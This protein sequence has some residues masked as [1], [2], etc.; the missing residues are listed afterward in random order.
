MLIEVKEN[1]TDCIYINILLPK[2]TRSKPLRL[3]NRALVLKQLE[4]AR[5]AR[6]V[7]SKAEF[8]RLWKNLTPRSVKF[9]TSILYATNHM[10]HSRERQRY[11]V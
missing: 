10:P 2:S 8:R 1:N 7:N 4:V 6:T 11:H 3:N 9:G 5:A